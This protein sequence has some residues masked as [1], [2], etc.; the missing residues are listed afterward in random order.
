MIVL[1]PPTKRKH[2]APPPVLQQTLP[3]ISLCLHPTTNVLTATE[4]YNFMSLP[5]TEQ[6]LLIVFSTKNMFE[7]H[8]IMNGCCEHENYRFI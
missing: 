4:H 8:K 7:K 5:K 6:L 1:A 3:S 2:P